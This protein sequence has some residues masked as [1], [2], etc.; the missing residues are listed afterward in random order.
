MRRVVVG[1]VG[2]VL[3]FVSL[4][5]P[6]WTISFPNSDPAQYWDISVYLYRTTMY[7]FPDTYPTGWFSCVAI[8]FVAAGAVFGLLG[9]LGVGKRRPVLIAAQILAVIGLFS[10]APVLRLPA[11][12]LKPEV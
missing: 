12:R 3:C 10:F 11:R 2:C 5:L 8:L 6:W 9:N 1:I 7:D 4:A